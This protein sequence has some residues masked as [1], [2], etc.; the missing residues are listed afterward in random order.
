MAGGAVVLGV[1]LGE[2]AVSTGAA[3]PTGGASLLGLLE[4]PFVAFFGMGII[5]GGLA[6]SAYGVKLMW[7][8]NVPKWEYN[9]ILNAINK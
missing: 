9:S 2:V 1:A 6:M 7:D 3:L 8:S 5:A 4:T